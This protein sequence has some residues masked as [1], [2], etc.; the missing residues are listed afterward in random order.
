MIL[1][2]DVSY[3][4]LIPALGETTHWHPS[5]KCLLGIKTSTIW[6]PTVYV[7]TLLTGDAINRHYGRS[8]E[9]WKRTHMFVNVVQNVR[10][11]TQELTQVTQ[12]TSI[13]VVFGWRRITMRFPGSWPRILCVLCTVIR[14]SYDVKWSAS[15]AIVVIHIRF[16]PAITV[17]V[18]NRS[19]AY[20]LVRPVRRCAASGLAA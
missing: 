6:P 9:V 5:S 12:A 13:P 15:P 2:S 3:V 11:P 7:R 18:T 17:I 16:S 19:L 10:T 8:G 1:P 14:R 20:S 4:V